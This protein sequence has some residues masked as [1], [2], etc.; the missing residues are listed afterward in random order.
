MVKVWGRPSFPGL[1]E[2]DLSCTLRAWEKLGKEQHGP[3]G[4]GAFVVPELCVCPM[5]QSCPEPVW[6]QRSHCVLAAASHTAGCGCA[7]AGAVGFTC[8]STRHRGSACPSLLLLPGLAARALEGQSEAIRVL[9]VYFAG[10][11]NFLPA[12]HSLINRSEDVG[13]EA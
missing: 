12:A 6:F 2:P 3:G 1:I 10:D 13:R 5:C 8:P 4:T 11:D 9:L 7:G